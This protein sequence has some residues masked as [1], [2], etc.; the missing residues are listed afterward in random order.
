MPFPTVSDAPDPQGDSRGETAGNET[1]GNETVRPAV[2]FTWASVQKDGVTYYVIGEDQDDEVELSRAK[3]SREK[4]VEALEFYQEYGYSDDQ[5]GVAFRR[6]P[7]EMDLVPKNPNE[8]LI[9]MIF[10]D[11]RVDEE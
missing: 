6:L 11:E 4:F 8:Q 1:A 5:A 3:M 2:N 7:M 9:F 10:F